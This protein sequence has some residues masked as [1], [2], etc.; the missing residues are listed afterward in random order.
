MWTNLKNFPDGKILNVYLI[1]WHSWPYC[2]CSWVFLNTWYSWPSQEETPPCQCR[3]CCMQKAFWNKYTNI[4]VL[5]SNVQCGEGILKHNHTHTH[6]HTN[7]RKHIKFDFATHHLLVNVHLKYKLLHLKSEMMVDNFILS[8][9]QPINRE[10]DLK[11]DIIIVE[12][13]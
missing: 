11:L 5:T 6:R 1:P 10:K 8:S 2:V 13:F 3:H 12:I 4:S 7:A 9:Y